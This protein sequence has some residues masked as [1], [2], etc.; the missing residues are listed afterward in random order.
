M[1]KISSKNSGSK[2]LL[3]RNLWSLPACV[4]IREFMADKETVDPSTRRNG[5]RTERLARVYFNRRHLH[6]HSHK[7]A[8]RF[9]KKQRQLEPE[10]EKKRENE[11][12]HASNIKRDEKFVRRFSPSSYTPVYLTKFKTY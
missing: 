8:H 3:N 7:R 10:S 4:K 5:P 2:I 1:S 12:E 9:T 6:T 11:K